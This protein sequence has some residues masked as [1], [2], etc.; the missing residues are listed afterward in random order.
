[1]DL[2]ELQSLARQKAAAYALDP[3]LVCAV[4]EQ[5]SGWDPAAI[6]FEKNWA[7][8]LMADDTII[9]QHIFPPSRDT[10][11]AQRSF[12]WGVMQVLGQTAREQG[13]T[14]PYLTRLCEPE[15]GLEFGCKVLMMKLKKAQG[16]VR[17]GLHY[18]NGGGDV[19]YP[20]AVMGRMAKYR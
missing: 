11:I 13:C 16:D 2:A 1:M 20:A 18:Y 7:F 10:E 9:G 3:A 19:T 6:R 4:A 8:R 5:E 12:S 14:Y 15:I 17:L